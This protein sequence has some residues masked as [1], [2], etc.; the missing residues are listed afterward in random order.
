ME[1]GGRYKFLRWV[2]FN[3]QLCSDHAFLWLCFISCIGMWIYIVEHVLKC[4][5]REMLNM[6]VA[7]RC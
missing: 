1:E 2:K 6:A 7:S 4:E 3:V 5:S